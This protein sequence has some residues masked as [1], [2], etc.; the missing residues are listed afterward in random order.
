MK[1]SDEEISEKDSSLQGV[2]FS[3]EVKDVLAAL[4]SLIVRAKAISI[5]R[6]KDGRVISDN[7]SSALRAVQ[8][9]LNDAWNEIDSLLSE[10]TP[11]VEATE[12]APAEEAPVEEIQEDAEVAAAEVVVEPEGEE[13][14]V[15]E[16]VE[17]QEEVVEEVEEV[18]EAPSLEEVDEEFEAL[19]AEAQ[20]NITESIIVEL[21]DEEV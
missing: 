4:E 6:E 11:V 5:L 20:Q 10:P 13:V 14:T 3:D 17:S 15:E 9:D 8:E 7:A 2:R 21:D 19:F 16:E 12:E 1:D 18:E